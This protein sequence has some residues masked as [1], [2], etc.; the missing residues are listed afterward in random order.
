MATFGK[1]S[2]GAS[3]S[4]SSSDKLYVSPAVP[5]SD[6][7]INSLTVRIWLSA[8]GTLNWRGV[9]YDSD[10]ASGK[11][12]TLLAVTDDAAT[13]Q[14]SEA[15]LTSNFT[16]A[17]RVFV[18]GGHTYYVG[19]HW[20]DPGTPSNTFSRGGTANLREE[21]LDTWSDGAPSTFS[22]SFT[23]AGEIDAYIDYTL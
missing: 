4:A 17:N 10:G 15:A 5:A 3:T 12:G 19:T 11:P 20:Q 18:T 14:T 16:G 13:T 23:G 6:G 8:A 2:N 7:Q 1:T 22:T 21:M 9:L